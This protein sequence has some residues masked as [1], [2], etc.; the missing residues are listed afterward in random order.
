MTESTASA[1]WPAIPLAE[2]HARLTA[3][4]QPFEMEERL[5]RGVKFRVWKNAPPTLRDVFLNSFA[6]KDRTFV[7]YQHERADYDSFARATL[8]LAEELR[9]RGV[10][11]GDRIAIVMRNLPE[12]PVAFFAAAISGAIATPLNAWWTG[13]ELEYALNDSGA[14]FAFVDAERWQRLE[15]HVAHCPALERIYV[16]RAGQAIEQAQVTQLEQLIGAVNEWPALPERSVPELTLDP[17]DDATIFYTS[18][19]TGKPK[20]ALGTHRTIVS[21]I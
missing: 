20:G 16:S 11:K 13:A 18:G 2:A 3:P 5:I 9:A 14:K 10:Q 12:W 7:V 15:S 6:F 1:S 21:N 19:T 8:A 17:E 4:G